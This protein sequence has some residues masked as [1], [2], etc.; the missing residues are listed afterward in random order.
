M[1]FFSFLPRMSSLSQ[2]CDIVG[3]QMV[4]NTGGGDRVCLNGEF[5]VFFILRY[6]NNVSCFLSLLKYNFV[7]YFYDALLNAWVKMQNRI[8][9]SF[10]WGLV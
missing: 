8:R 9:I 10:L 3:Y 4:N 2:E 6:L 5:V 1:F 7:C